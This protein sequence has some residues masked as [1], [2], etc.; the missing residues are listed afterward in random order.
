MCT[1]VLIVI[2]AYDVST[3]C[4]SLQRTA[5]GFTPKRKKR[6]KVWE[7]GLLEELK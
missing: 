1:S 6:K 3:L 5:S 7:E 4:G 2:L